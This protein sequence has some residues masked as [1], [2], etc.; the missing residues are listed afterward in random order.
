MKLNLDC[1]RA[2]LFAV[3]DVCDMK[4]IFDSANDIPLIKGGY[5]VEEILYH[6]RQCN[7]AGMFHG[8]RADLG[9]NFEV[10]DLSPRGH[11]FLANI[12]ED[13]IWHKVKSISAEVGSRSLDAVSQIAS[14]VIT[15]II[16]SQFGLR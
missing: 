11:E 16:K 5:S 12:R 3:E 2:I 6:A 10:I 4:R 8:Y 1:T 14:L 13:N 9:G 15:E 7:L